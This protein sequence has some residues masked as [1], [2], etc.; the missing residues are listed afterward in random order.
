[1]IRAAAIIGLILGLAAPAARAQDAPVATAAPDQ[2]TDLESDA[3]GDLLADPEAYEPEAP[4]PAAPPPAPV[5]APLVIAPPP[6]YVPP[7]VV[8]RPRLERP[9][10]VDEAGLSPEGPLGAPELGYDL[11]LRAG[12]ASAQGRQGALDGGWTVAGADG[13]KL[14]NLQLVDP[15]D[16]MGMLEGAWR[17]LQ[18]QGVGTTGLLTSLDRGPTALS[19]R[20]SR[21]TPENITV[22]TLQ[23]A[24]DGSWTGEMWEDGAVKPV[25]M[26][27]N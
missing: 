16:G 14:Y 1:L 5:P 21:R 15:G 7:P 8:V 3:I 17:S 4:E 24:V 19:V 18:R 11:R 27:R 26:R 6:L 9:V 10:N 25:T 20:F 13:A 2:S 12:V 23:P 22:L